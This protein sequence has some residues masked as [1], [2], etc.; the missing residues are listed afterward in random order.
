[1]FGQKASTG[2]PVQLYY[3]N[4]RDAGNLYTYPIF[5]STSQ[6]L[7][8]QFERPIDDLV[9]TTGE[10][11]DMPQE[12]GEAL[13]WNLAWRLCPQYEVP[14]VK[15]DMIQELAIFTYEMVDGWDQEVAS[16]QMQPDYTMFM[17]N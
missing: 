9:A 3:D 10:D 8:V 16:I 11:F 12:W 4:Q 6:L 7:F 13:M 14:K 2:T 15:K 17:G 1:M 5:S